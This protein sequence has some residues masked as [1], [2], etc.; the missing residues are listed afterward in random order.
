MMLMGGHFVFWFFV[1]F[2]I[3]IDL[4][5]RCRRL[6]TRKCECDVPMRDDVEIDDDVLAEEK[7]VADTEPE[8]FRIKVQNLRKVYWLDRFR[9]RRTKK[10]KELIGPTAC[11]GIPLVAVENLSF[12]L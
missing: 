4:G 8:K 7:R 12:G 11:S 9:C 2:L 3:E 5:K 10:E 6:Y 1:L